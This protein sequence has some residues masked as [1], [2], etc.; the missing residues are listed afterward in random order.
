MG[1]WHSCFPMNFAKFLRTSFLTEHLR[2]LL[3]NLRP[4]Y[5]EGLFYFCIYQT[6]ANF[7]VKNVYHPFIVQTT[8]YSFIFC[9][10]FPLSF[11]RIGYY[12]LLYFVYIT[13]NITGYE[14]TITERAILRRCFF[15]LKRKRVNKVSFLNP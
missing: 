6:K 15:L 7:M 5:P 9:Q 2:W 12:H 4:I 3:L 10:M 14:R 8:Q 13:R 11:L 1:L